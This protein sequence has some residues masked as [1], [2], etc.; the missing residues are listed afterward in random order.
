MAIFGAPVSEP[1][2][3]IYAVKAGLE[4]LEACHA[5]M[6][7]WE[8]EGKP[9]FQMRMGVNSGPVIAGNLGSP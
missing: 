3:A 5:L 4:M 7:K 8:G 9:T 1:D 2:H 6:A